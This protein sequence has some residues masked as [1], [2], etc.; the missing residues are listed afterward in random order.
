MPL[1]F[2]RIENFIHLRTFRRK[3]TNIWNTS[4]N[5]VE[6]APV[7]FTEQYGLTQLSFSSQLLCQSA[8]TNTVLMCNTEREDMHTASHMLQLEGDQHAYRIDTTESQGGEL[9]KIDQ[10]SPPD[11]RWP[12]VW[13]LT[14]ILYGFCPRWFQYV[15]LYSGFIRIENEAC[16]AKI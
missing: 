7:P 6:R 11:D 16:L 13:F 10:S 14:G 5:R 9:L 15:A 3:A 4:N 12:S 1:Y 8:T 2:T